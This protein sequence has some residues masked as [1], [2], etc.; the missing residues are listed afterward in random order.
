MRSPLVRPDL[1]QF[2]QFFSSSFCSLRSFVSGKFRFSLFTKNN[3]VILVRD[4]ARGLDILDL[5]EAR[6]FPHLD[7]G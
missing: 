5:L 3:K 4:F 2:L 6:K 7:A 1:P